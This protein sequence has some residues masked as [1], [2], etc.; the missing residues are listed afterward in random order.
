MEQ[1]GIFS[2]QGMTFIHD[3]K[4]QQCMDNAWHL[5]TFLG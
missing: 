5:E 4:A 2:I 1:R 3:I